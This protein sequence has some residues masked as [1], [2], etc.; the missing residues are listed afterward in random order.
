M[1]QTL[2]RPEPSTARIRTLAF[3][4]PLIEAVHVENAEDHLVEGRAIVLNLDLSP[5]AVDREPRFWIPPLSSTILHDT[6]IRSARSLLVLRGGLDPDGA[7]AAVTAQPGWALL[8]ELLPEG[9]FPREVPLWRSPQ[10]EAGRA[11]FVPEAVLRQ[12]PRGRARDYRVLVNLWFAPAGTDCLIHNEHAFLEVHTQVAGRGR[13]QKFAR[14]DHASLYQDVL[15]SPGYT[16]PEPFC[17]VGDDGAFSYPWH[18]YRGDTDCV[19]LAVEYHELA[20]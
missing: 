8:G 1:T 18:Q 7:D 20:E 14:A 13:M 6:R 12:H 3:S 16:T 5:V 11:S 9:A 15:M 2:H 4:G 17:Q 19:W 10:D